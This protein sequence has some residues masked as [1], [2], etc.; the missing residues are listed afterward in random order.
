MKKKK[1]FQRVFKKKKLSLI[2]SLKDTHRLDEYLDITSIDNEGQEAFQNYYPVQPR[3]KTR[4]S[5][6]ETIE[7]EFAFVK[8]DPRLLRFI[9]NEWIK[10]ARIDSS[11]EKS[12][13]SWAEEN[14]FEAETKESS[15][16]EQRAENEKHN[17]NTRTLCRW[18]AW[19][20]L[21]SAYNDYDGDL[22]RDL[23]SIERFDHEDKNSEG[24]QGLHTDQELLNA[25]I[26]LN[27][28]THGCYPD[29]ILSWLL[30]KP[31]I[32]NFRCTDLSYEIG[33]RWVLDT[34]EWLKKHEILLNR[35]EFENLG[36]SAV[37]FV[38]V[39]AV[40]LRLSSTLKNSCIVEE[41]ELP[42]FVP[43]EQGDLI[44]PLPG[45]AAD[46][47]S[48]SAF[49]DSNSQTWQVHH[50]DHYKLIICDEY[51]SYCFGNLESTHSINV[52]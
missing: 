45:F 28:S 35:Q 38:D 4:T 52:K 3:L 12:N 32:P 43:Q 44:P 20:E 24:C 13:Y 21:R 9:S 5:F 14:I 49:S 6:R 26:C 27:T 41:D 8:D 29:D 11:S 23:R 1:K 30:V 37:T 19:K 18:R 7:K 15:T 50:P 34:E 22:R 31:P 17:Q 46:E 2:Q 51:P 48:V 36:R 40:G 25:V 10:K 39:E 33:Y 42:E 16:F 47:V